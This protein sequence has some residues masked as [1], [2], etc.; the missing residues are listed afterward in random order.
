[1][2]IWHL[3]DCSLTHLLLKQLKVRERTDNDLPIVCSFS[4]S[5]ILVLSSSAPFFTSLSHTVC[6][7]LIFLFISVLLLA[8]LLSSLLAGEE[9]SSHA[10]VLDK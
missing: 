2:L 4:L 10:A 9:H 6:V 1:M 8:H 7:S 5:C 3:S